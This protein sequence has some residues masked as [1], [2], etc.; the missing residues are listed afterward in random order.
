MWCGASCMIYRWQGQTAVV[1]SEGGL[2][3]HHWGACEW[4]P[5]VIPITSGVH[6]KEKRGHCNQALYTVALTLLGTY[7]PCSCHCQ[8]LWVMPRHLVTVLS[9][10]PTTRSNWYSTICV[11]S[12][13]Q[14]LLAWS[15]GSRGKLPQLPLQRWAWRTA[16]GDM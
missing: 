16:I 8:M 13:E 9:Q 12:V 5:P 7:P 11:G 3:C 15:A 6:K 4:A 1:I 2:T 14:V 10:D